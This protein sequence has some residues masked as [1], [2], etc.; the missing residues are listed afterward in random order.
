LA[1]D[2]HRRAFE[3][4]RYSFSAKAGGSLR[5]DGCDFCLL[6]YRLTVYNVNTEVSV[7]LEMSKTV[8][9]EESV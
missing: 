6:N 4:S 1:T 9:A 5:G 3:E 2:C 8:Q 7:S